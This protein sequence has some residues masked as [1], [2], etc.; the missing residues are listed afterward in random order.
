[1]IA[2]AQN[3]VWFSV[4]KSKQNHTIHSQ[5]YAFV[6]ILAPHAALFHAHIVAMGVS[7]F[8]LFRP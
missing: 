1:M 6:A 8:Q 5:N 2:L 7:K 3:G 4:L